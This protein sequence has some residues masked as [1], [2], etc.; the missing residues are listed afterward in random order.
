MRDWLFYWR[1]EWKQRTTIWLSPN[2]MNSLND[3]RSKA[4]CKSRSEFIEQAIQFYSEYNDA[5]NK[6]QH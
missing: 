6:G 5:M 4:N 3:M 1:N 2:I